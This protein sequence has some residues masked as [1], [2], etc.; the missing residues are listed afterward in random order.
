MP[1]KRSAPRLWLDKK[2]HQWVIRDGKNFIRTGCSEGEHEPAQKQLAKYLAK[3]WEPEIVASPLVADILAVYAREHV[4]KTRSISNTLYNIQSLSTFWDDKRLADVTPEATRSYAMGRTAAAARR[5]L[6]VLG[7]AI[8]YW[9]QHKAPVVRPTIVL[10]R[11]NTPRERWLTRSEAARLLW[12][13]RRNERL[14]RFILLGLY[15]GSRSGVVLDTRWDWVDWDSGVLRRRAARAAQSATKR[16]P[17]VKLGRRI[18]AH[19]RRWYRLDQVVGAEYVVHVDGKRMRKMTDAFE[20]AVQRAGLED[21][22]PHILRHTRA[23]WLV[24]SGVSLWECAGALGMTVQILERTYGHHSPEY[25]K[26]AA[27]V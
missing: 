23:T 1:R 20:R 5:D 26:N 3:K 11:R 15:T 27:E 10:P 21:V 2:R 16:T 4:P 24:Q 13:A 6:E 8:S 14:R 22:H 17:P 19:L 9:H 25:Q 18:F 7:A 12:A